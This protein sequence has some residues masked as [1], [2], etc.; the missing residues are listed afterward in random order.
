MIERFQAGWKHAMDFPHRHGPDKPGH[1]DEGVAL[2]GIP[3]TVKAL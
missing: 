3:V 1:D 2:G